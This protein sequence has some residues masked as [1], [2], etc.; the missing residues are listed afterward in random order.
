MINTKFI[1]EEGYNIKDLLRM[2]R[3]NGSPAKTVYIH[4]KNG[5]K[6]FKAK[7]NKLNNA[8]DLMEGFK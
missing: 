7:I 2:I 6:K 3:K 4:T 8:V 1:S 5:V